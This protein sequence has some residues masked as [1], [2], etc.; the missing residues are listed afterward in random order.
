MLSIYF[1][2]QGKMKTCEKV[3]M[4]CNK[5]GERQRRMKGSRWRGNWS[6]G[7]END[8]GGGGRG[9]WKGARAGVGEGECKRREEGVG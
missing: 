1:Q 8:G 7:G 3:Y 5:D 4:T 6:R 2:M 9:E